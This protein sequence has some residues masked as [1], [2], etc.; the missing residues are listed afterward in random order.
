M[1]VLDTNTL[2]YFFKGV[3]NVGREL[4][5]RSPKQIAIPSIVLF[6]L[7]VGI[8]KSNSPEKRT[9]QL[10]EIVSLVHFIP[11]GDQEARSAATLR[12]RLEREGRPIG[13]CDVMIAG[14]ALAHDATLVSHNT[15][16]FKRI[17]GL[18]LEDWL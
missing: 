14:T 2:I 11:F 1:Y 18:R 15:S 3:G 6:E 16:E 5:S 9:E 13:P 8:A 4:L 17:D 10:R 7:E 12:A